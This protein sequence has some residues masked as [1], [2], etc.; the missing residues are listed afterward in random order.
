MITIRL[1]CDI[2]EAAA[3]LVEIASILVTDLSKVTADCGFLVQWARP[4]VGKSARGKV[5]SLL[6]QDIARSTDGCD[7]RAGSR[8]L[9]LELGSVLAIVREAKGS[10]ARVTRGK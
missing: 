7:P 8:E 5:S 1:S 4:E 10:C 2:R 9:R 6:G 3:F